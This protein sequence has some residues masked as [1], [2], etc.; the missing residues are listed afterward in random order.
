MAWAS[1]ET[2]TAISEYDKNG[3]IKKLQRA[4]DGVQKDNLTYGYIGN[5]LQ[6]VTDAENNSEGFNNG[7]SGTGDDYLYDGN[8][9]ATKDANRNIGTNGIVYSVHNLVQQVTITGGATLTYIYDV[10]G[11][12]LRM[13]NTN[14][15]VNTKYT[16]PF[17]YNQGNYL[18]RI[19]TEEGQIFVTNNGND[20]AFEYYLQDHLGNT[21]MVM[22]EPG[23]P[24]QETEYFPFGLA[25]PKVAGTSLYNGKEKQP[26]AGQWTRFMYLIRENWLLT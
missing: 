6:K 12:K 8:G 24:T 3:N 25:I 22:N 18:T 7:S 21:R 10:I 4:F 23:T 17:E 16:G 13:A 19:A 2:P 11:A 9:N 5:Q 26:E 20:F 14:G 15:A 1:A